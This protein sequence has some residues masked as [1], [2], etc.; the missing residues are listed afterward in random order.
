[1]A[2][3]LVVQ[4]KTSLLEAVA[5][6]DIGGV[7]AALEGLG[8]MELSK[9]VLERSGVGAAVGPL[10]KHADAELA[11]HSTQLVERWKT[12]LRAGPPSSPAVASLA[13]TS[14][15][16]SASALS[17]SGSA[18]P[19]LVL[20]P[21][22]SQDSQTLADVKPKLE[23]EKSKEKE[24]AERKD[25]EPEKKLKKQ[26]SEEEDVKTAKKPKKE[27][28][29]GAD[30][31]PTRSKIRSLL[32]EALSVTKVEDQTSPELLA[33]DI[34]RNLFELCQ[35]SVTEEY[36]SKARL[37]FLNLKN[38]K[39]PELRESVIKGE[40]LAEV[41][42]KMSSAE[43]ASK[44]LIRQREATAEWFRKASILGSQLEQASTDMFRCGRCK[45][46]KCSY[47]QLQIRSADEPMTTFITCM[48][49][50]NR[51]KMN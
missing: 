40:I 28:A 17:V 50:G 35:S 3:D 13:S 7:K 42:V 24:L 44:D 18:S 19:A 8:K 37:L 47:Y 30:S 27:S 43:L 16:A 51:W 14:T 36:K 29:S 15:S 26:K 4:L 1:M 20:T 10:R 31:D 9:E 23:R 6:K 25:S 46:R 5:K 32:V 48:N 33:S 39:N 2:M 38:T 21:S 45:E 12:L 11:A 49:C 34:E 41:L 22:S